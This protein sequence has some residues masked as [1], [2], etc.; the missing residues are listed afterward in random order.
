MPAMPWQKFGTPNPNG[1]Y[2]A[3]ISYL[4]LKSSRGL[5][6]LVGYAVRVLRQLAKADGLIGYSLFAYLFSKQ[7]WTLSVWRDEAA[8]QAFVHHPP[9]LKSMGALAPYMTE[10]KFVRWAVK[11]S[12]LPLQWNDAMKRVSKT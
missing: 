11:G 5:F 12:A 3:L 2:L 8:L 10:T 1:E 6:P 7:F 4:P 9:H